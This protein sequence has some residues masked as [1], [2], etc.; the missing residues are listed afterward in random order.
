MSAQT[1]PGSRR[2]PA[3]HA[4]TD[5][6]A[7]N[8]PR[9]ETL[10]PGENLPV[11][12]Q[13]R[14]TRLVGAG[15]WT[16]VYRA[17]PSGGA[18]R[19]WG[20]FAVKLLAP[21]FA[22]DSLA[23]ALLRREAQISRQVQHPQLATVLADHSSSE[24]PHLVLPFLEGL[25]LAEVVALASGGCQ[26]PDNAALSGGLRL[27]LAA[28]PPRA[29]DPIGTPQR[30]FSKVTA[31]LLV[32]QIAEA[33]A[34]LHHAGWLH[35]DVKPENIRVGPAGHAT[36]IDLGLARQLGSESC[37]A[38]Y[39]LATTLAYAAPE[40]FSEGE[41]LSGAADIYSLGIVLWELLTGRPP[42]VADAVEIVDLHRRQ[43]LPDLRSLRGDV[44]DD[45]AE[46]VRLM[47]AKEPLRR[48]EAPRLVRM[49]VEQ[50]IAALGRRTD[51]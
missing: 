44:N 10:Q 7:Q 46:V 31:L 35:G 34:A 30:A 41:W 4:L 9:G 2:A 43:S 42:F 39:V 20:D 3:R 51:L 47:L 36:L 22:D 27:P 29:F 24:P 25:S 17:R 1:I 50:E 48:P 28:A 38:R 33:L 8:L 26:S 6:V 15:Q 14:L 37:S 5:G 23:R 32:R 13:W 49:L 12:G 11:V 16:R 45:L 18:D 19:D 40:S 21:E